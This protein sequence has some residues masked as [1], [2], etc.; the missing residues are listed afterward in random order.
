M[1]KVRRKEKDYVCK[2]QIL[3]IIKKKLTEPPLPILQN[4]KILMK[5]ETRMMST[6]LVS[7]RNT[8]C[9]LASLSL[10][11]TVMEHIALAMLLCNR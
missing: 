1:R 9:Q 8:T 3:N 2:D 4:I 6:V 11:S 5:N 7:S 10:N